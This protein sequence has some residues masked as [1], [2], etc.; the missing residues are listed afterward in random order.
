M[1]CLQNPQGSAKGLDQYWRPNIISPPTLD[2]CQAFDANICLF[3]TPQKFYKLH[4][5][6]S[7]C[8]SLYTQFFFFLLK[9]CPLDTKSHTLTHSFSVVEV[10]SHYLTGASVSITN[11]T[12]VLFCWRANDA[13]TANFLRTTTKSRLISIISHAYFPDEYLS[14]CGDVNQFTHHTEGTCFP[15]RDRMLVPIMHILPSLD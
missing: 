15:F 8:Q 12:A 6:S 11:T 1:L 3:H 2:K 13:I 9:V 7:E 4:H 14:C 5:I 10:S